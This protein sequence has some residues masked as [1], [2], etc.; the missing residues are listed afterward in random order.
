MSPSKHKIVRVLRHALDYAERAAS[1][2]DDPSTWEV[3]GAAL[4]ALNEATQTLEAAAP[5]C[6]VVSQAERAELDAVVVRLRQA[7]E[8]LGPKIEQHLGLPPKRL[9]SS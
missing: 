8:R 9:P 2:P 1:A 3:F 5:E 7:L 6:F 4:T